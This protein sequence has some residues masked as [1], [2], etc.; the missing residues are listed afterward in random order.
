MS[1][2]DIATSCLQA[3]GSGMSHLKM[4]NV[5]RGPQMHACLQL[6]I[7]EVNKLAHELKN[8]LERLQKMNE[9]S[10]TRKVRPCMVSG[11]SDATCVRRLVLERY[12]D[13]LD[14]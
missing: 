6:D 11:V 5:C 9:A 10:L 8:R 1:S 2:L 12:A 4:L 13:N 14:P 3:V 7:N